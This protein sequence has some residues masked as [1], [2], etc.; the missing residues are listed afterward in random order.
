MLKLPVLVKVGKKTIEV[1]TLEIDVNVRPNG[2]IAPPS[3]REI[4]KAMKKVKF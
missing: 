2:E 4:R 1:G 3:E